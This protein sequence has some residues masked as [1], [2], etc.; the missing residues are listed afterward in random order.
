MFLFGTVLT[1]AMVVIYTNLGETPL[2]AVMVINSLMFIGITARMSPSQ[3]L[4][5][6]IPEPQSRG[7]YMAIS[8]SVQ[9]MAGGLGS[10][11]AGAIVVSQADGSILHFEKVGYAVIGASLFTLL[12]MTRIHRLIRESGSAPKAPK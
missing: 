9:Q 5:S 6:A 10:I 8:S 1:I 3:A 2:A 4:M 11:L 12:M 7:S